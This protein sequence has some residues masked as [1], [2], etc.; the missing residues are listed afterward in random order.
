V[1]C[2]ISI[3][4]GFTYPLDSSESLAKWRNDDPKTS[5]GGN[6]DSLGDP[7][8]SVRPACGGRPTVKNLLPMGKTR[9]IYHLWVNIWELPP[10]ASKKLR[11]SRFSNVAELL[12]Q[13]SPTLPQ[14]TD[15]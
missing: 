11:V 9:F 2:S 10:E 8:M 5:S 6:L 14:L 4:I 3:R 12:P 7:N 13:I 15:S 1:R